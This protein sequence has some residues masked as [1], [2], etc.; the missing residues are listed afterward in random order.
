VERDPFE[1][2]GVARTATEAEIIS[3]YSFLSLV[4]R[5]ARWRDA[6]SEVHLEAVHWTQALDEALRVALRTTRAARTRPAD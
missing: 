4:F 3:A 2:L 1:L 5:P 6:P